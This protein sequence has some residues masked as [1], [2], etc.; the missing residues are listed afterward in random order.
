[1]T[2]DRPKRSLLSIVNP[3][4][5]SISRELTAA[6]II[7]IVVASAIAMSIS[8]F[9][10][11]RRAEEQL[12]NKASEYMIFLKDILEIPLWNLDK[13]SIENIG[14]SYAQNEFVQGLRII[15]SWGKVYF[16]MEKEGEVPLARKTGDVSHKGESVGHVELSLTS[17]YYK[18]INRQR[19]WSS[20]FTMIIVV[21]SLIIVTGFLLRVFLRKPL[22]YLGEIVNSYASGK[23]D[24]SGHRMSFIEFQPF[25]TVLGKMGDKIKFQMTELRKHQEHLEELVEERTSELE[26]MS[27]HKSEFLANMSHE[28]RT[29]LT[30]IFGYTKLILD[31]L[32]GDINKEQQKD[33]GIV[34]TSSKHLLELI[35]DLLD[36]SRIEAGKT[37]L[38]YETFTIPELLD[39][40]VP[41]M[42]RLAKDKGLTLTYSVASDIDSLHADKAKT[43]QVLI[44]ILG[45]A[46]KFTNAGSIKLNVAETDSDFVFS[47]T[48][49]GMGM[50][51]EDLEAIFDSFKQ[52]GP[53]HM[54]DHE[55][56]GLGLAI[57]K[58]F[59]EMHDGKIWVESEL[60]KGS[61][62]TFT[63][64]REKMPDPES[65]PT[66][67]R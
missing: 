43:K 56:T 10:A 65:C 7:T 48:D 67:W 32:E 2:E 24:S 50:R 1:M 19:L 61:T 47:V 41:V 3:K 42:E 6:L 8:Y 38:S 17:Y 53:A 28:L 58:Q 37:V 63:L 5:R 51:N 15:D 20:G 54:A 27:R 40:V 25:V 23:Y 36:L 55:G 31:G 22:D 29:P 57:S 21:I 35:N 62:F 14:R 52:V 26:K 46:I 18:E 34:L 30:S 33:L 12:E 16:Q 66:V 9:N 49:A 11:T 13:E 64:P 59:I 39:D 60:G 44:N 45:N 4:K